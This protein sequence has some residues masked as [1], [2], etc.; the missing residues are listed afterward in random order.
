LERIIGQFSK[1]DSIVADF[2]CGSGTTLAVGGRMGRG[3]I[4]CDSSPIAIAFTKKRL[5]TGF[6]V[7]NIN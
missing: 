6:A 3:W 5:G 7:V 1:R 2:F 4:G